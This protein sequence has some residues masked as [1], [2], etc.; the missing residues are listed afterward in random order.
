MKHTSARL[1]SLLLSG[2]IALS[3]QPKDLTLEDIYIDFKFDPLLIDDIRWLPGQSKFL[4]RYDDSLKN[5]IYAFDL[6]MQETEVF[7]AADDFAPQGTPVEI[8]DY[9]VDPSGTWLLVGS[10]EIKIWRHSRS[11]SFHLVDLASDRIIPLTENN[12]NLRNPKFS[13]DGKLVA[14]VRD[15]DLF[16]YD[17]ATRWEKRLTKDGSADILNGRF[18]WVYEEEFGS[19]DGYRWSPDSRQIA[20]WR[21]DQSRVPRFTLID[22]LS[23]YPVTSTIAY[24]KVGENNPEVKIGVVDV[25]RGRTRWMDTAGGFEHYLPRI[26]WTAGGEHLAIQRLN[27]KQNRLELLLADPRTGATRVILT[28]T[29]PC[30]VDMTDDWRFLTDDTFI[31]TSERSGFRHAYRYNLNGTVLDTLT[32]GDWEVVEVTAVD[33]TAGLLYFTGNRESVL[34]QHLYAVPLDGG[35]LQRLTSAAGFH[36]VRGALDGRHFIDFHSAA[37]RPPVVDL[38]D[39]EGTKLAELA[40]TDPDML[41][42]YNLT[43]PDFITVITDDSMILNARITLPRDFDPARQYP[44]IVFGYGGPGSQSVQNQWGNR[45]YLWHQY[46]GQQGYIGFA[47]DNRGTGGRGKAFKN[48]AYGDLSA[49]LVRDQIAGVEYLRSLPYVDPGRIGIWGWSGGGYMA[50]CC[51]TRASDYFQV[52]VAVAP[53]T[54][55][56]LYDTIWTERYMGLLMENESGYE[57]AS[58]LNSVDCFKG[59]L[60]LIHGSGDDNVHPQNSLQLADVCVKQG[61]FVDL[62]FYANKNH[63]IEGDKTTYNVFKRIADYFLD[64]L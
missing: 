56:R 17:I 7:Y 32:S 13:P 11:G 24:P 42:G 55:F 20:F 61:K 4:F 39:G 58:V 45:N 15:N 48:L 31:W 27:R 51:L 62:Y 1:I 12:R 46:L 25:T 8:D 18:G 22:E 53:V 29:D 50:A 49:L 19:A 47:I 30:W 16:V 34:E 10:A 21:E 9:Q 28:E 33:D 2:W 41:A 36:D 14:F 54:D 63:R 3:A 40:R 64:N 6:I 37:D 57:R 38:L 26:T 23:R 59:R 44:V 60:L 35:A 52:G 5:D 43:R